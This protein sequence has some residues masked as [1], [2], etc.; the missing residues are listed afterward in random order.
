MV[1]YRKDPREVLQDMRMHPTLVRR[2]ALGAGLALYGVG[3]GVATR[4]AICAIAMFVGGAILGFFLPAGAIL[5]AA[6]PTQ[7][8]AAQGE[9]QQNA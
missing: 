1:E 7:A 3:F 9:A 4:S 6:A 8:P 5:D 2:I